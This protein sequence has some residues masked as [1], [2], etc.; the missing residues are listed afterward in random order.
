VDFV[1]PFTAPNLNQFT[2][3][4]AGSSTK[5]TWAIEGSSIY[6]AKMMSLFV[7]LDRAMGKHFEAGLN[8]LRMV[9]EK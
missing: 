4:P 6:M 8:N 7:N 2:L 1:K 3:E 9:A 5:V